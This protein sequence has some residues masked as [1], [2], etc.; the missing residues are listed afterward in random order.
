MNTILT[1]LSP[2]NT[3]Q[4]LAAFSS[5][6]A[7]IKTVQLIRNATAHQ[8]AET[9]QGVRQRAS[10]YIAAPIVHPLQAIFWIDPGTKDFLLLHAIEEMR[11]SSQ[12]AIA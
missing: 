11:D 8:N 2:S 7:P 3:S 1:R 12:A 10:A 4:L 9:L 6:H 5:A